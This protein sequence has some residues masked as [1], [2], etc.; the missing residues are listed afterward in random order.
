MVAPPIT[1]QTD[2]K[3]VVIPWAMGES[4]VFCVVF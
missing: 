2:N 1:P 3:I 4:L